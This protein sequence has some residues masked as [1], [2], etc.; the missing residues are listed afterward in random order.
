MGNENRVEIMIDDKVAEGIYVNSGN[1]MYNQSEFIIDFT[2]MVPPPG[3]PRVM[4][5]IIMTPQQAKVFLK[6][7]EQ[8]IENYEKQFGAIPANSAQ[9]KKVG[10]NQ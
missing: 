5:R 6:A 1:I 9:E 7:V 8:N 4:S 2:R 3:K 10:F